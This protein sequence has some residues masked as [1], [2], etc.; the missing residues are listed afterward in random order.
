MDAR[1]QDRRRRRDPARAEGRSLEA[2]WGED[3][4]PAIAPSA[5]PHPLHG[6]AGGE[7][8]V[9]V[10]DVAAAT[11][12]APDSA[13]GPVDRADPAPRRHPRTVRWRRRAGTIAALLLVGVLAV[14]LPRLLP[15]GEGPEQVAEDFLQ[16]LVDGD[17]DQVREHVQGSPDTSDAALTGEILQSAADRVRDAEV[18]NIQ[19]G[20][21]TAEV[22]VRM[23]NGEETIETTLMLRADSTSAFAA[24]SWELQP[25]EVPE[26]RVRLPRGVDGF[27]VNGIRV[28]TEGRP[29]IFD[30][31]ER[32]LLVQLLPGTYEFALPE[33][34][35]WR[36]PRA[37]TV[38]IPP[39]LGS[40]TGFADVVYDLSEAGHEEVRR[41]VD[42]HLGSCE[43]ST[44]PAPH[45][46]P[47]RLPEVSDAR[48]GDPSLQG[49]WDVRV[50]PEVEVQPSSAMLWSVAGVPGRAAFTPATATGGAGSSAVQ[51]VPVE[52]RGFVHLAPDGDL[53]VVLRPD[54]SVTI[55]L[56][57]D[58]DTREPTGFV[59][60]ENGA[61]TTAREACRG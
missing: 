58:P 20:S 15:S 49:T 9:P 43:A 55:T 26:V 33:A 42:K 8:A 34:G 21:G 54:E 57:T 27:T 48:A 46:C 14:G 29:T 47:F 30:G 5:S 36:V 45:R 44:S 31:A 17:I 22:T 2:G 35:P 12:E 60:V 56:C 19:R 24:V 52:V 11:S 39:V 13:D 3:P 10:G 16:A 38:E 7:A 50:P 1:E 23:D 40:W 32:A 59:H 51:L 18:A 4:D 61:M 53:G 41:Q 25:V 6:A 37:I 28:S